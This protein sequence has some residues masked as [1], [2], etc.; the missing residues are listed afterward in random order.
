MGSHAP[1]GCRAMVRTQDV[2]G[3][4][5]A[6]DRVWVAFV[7]FTLPKRHTLSRNK[8]RVGVTGSMGVAVGLLAGDSGSLTRTRA[9]AAARR[10][11]TAAKGLC[12]AD[13]DEG[14]ITVGSA[15]AGPCLSL[16]PALHAAAFRP[17]QR[18]PVWGRCREQSSTR[19][20]VLP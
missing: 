18:P 7:A 6:F 1:P 10:I 4:C 13:A 15:T 12:P 3:V 11:P 5:V 2:G 19:T 16:L 20:S 8:G 14:S 17:A 9:T